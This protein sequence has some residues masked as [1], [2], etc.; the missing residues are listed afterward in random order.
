M[1][2]AGGAKRWVFV[3]RSAGVALAQDVRSFW[4]F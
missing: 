3:L 1:V 4:I 2:W